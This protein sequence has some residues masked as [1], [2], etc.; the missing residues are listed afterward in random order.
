MD[1]AAEWSEISK[2]QLCGLKGTI[3]EREKDM[4]THLSTTTRRTAQIYCQHLLGEIQSI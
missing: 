4:N 3:R 1:S 2:I